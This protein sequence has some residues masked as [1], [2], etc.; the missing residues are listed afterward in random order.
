MIYLNNAATTYPKPECVKKAVEQTIALPPSAQ[1]RTYSGGTN[2]NSGNFSLPSDVIGEC[3][4]RLADFFHISDARRIYF[5]SGATQAMN[6]IVRGLCLDGAHVVITQNEHNAVLR[7]IYNIP[8]NASVSVAPCDSLGRLRLSALQEMITPD[9]AAVFVNHCSNVT[10]AVAPLAKIS[11]MAHRNGSLLIVDASQSAG[12]LPVDVEETGIDILCFT[13]HKGLY[14]IQGIGGFYVREGV[15]FS[16]SEFG[17]T[18]IDSRTVKFEH[19]HELSQ[20]E[21]GTQNEPGI[22]GLLAGLTFLD[23]T[24]RRT[25]WD[26]EQALL[27]QL[28]DGMNHLTNQ[29]PTC[30]LT[31]YCTGQAPVLSFTMD[32]MRPQDIG[33]LLA[34]SFDITVRTGLHCAPLIHRAMGTERDGTVRVSLSYFN[35]EEDVKFFL[36]AVTQIVEASSGRRA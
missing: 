5:T 26:K 14:G 25:I 18:G 8:R 32:T 23:E 24:G 1:F 36:D 29:Y 21:V 10:G 16:L 33:Y 19:V 27:A 22:A 9:T 28:M 35:T 17:G 7:T 3:K 6:R 34:H 11:E 20:M 13:G 4:K 30:G 2:Q 12:V 15:S 31:C